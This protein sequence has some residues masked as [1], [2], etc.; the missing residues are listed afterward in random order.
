MASD[1]S[2]REKKVLLYT[3]QLGI[4]SKAE[5]MYRGSFLGALKKSTD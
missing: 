2:K 3:A 4:R 5:K 1:K